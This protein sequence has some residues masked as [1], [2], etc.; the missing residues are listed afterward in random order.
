MALLAMA[1]PILPGKVEQFKSF[2]GQLDGARK[3]D[4]AASRK[5]LGVRERAF[6][7]QT[8][9]GDFVVVTLQGDDPAGAF[10]KFGQGDDPFTKWFVAQ[11]KEIHGVDLTAP[12]PDPPPT[13]VADSGK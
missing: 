4:F 5:K 9:A 1:V 3:A 12:P 2:V 6:H 8:P 7:Q 11:V 10:A 13:L